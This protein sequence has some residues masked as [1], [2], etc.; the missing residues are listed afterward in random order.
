MVNYFTQIYNSTNPYNFGSILEAVKTFVTAD[1]NTRLS[2][3][4]KD[5][6]VV[7]ALH[8]MYPT[9]SPGLDDMPALFYL[10]F[11]HIVGPKVTKAVLEILNSGHML[12]KINYTYIAL[13]PKK[14]EPKKVTDFRPISLCNV[15]YKLVSKVIATQLK[16]ILPLVISESQSAFVPGRQITDNV[17]VAFEV[18]HHLNRKNKGKMGQM[19]LKLDVSKAYDRV[20]WPFVKAIMQKMDFNDKWVNLIMECISTISI[21]F[22]THQWRTKRIY[23]SH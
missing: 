20:E 6:E 16:T 14:G 12:R 10:K 23:S 15:I 21:V 22:C 8:Q 18:M 1:M 2:Q 17:I 13:I 5:D 3:E 4:F 7:L 19:A 9:K 11:W